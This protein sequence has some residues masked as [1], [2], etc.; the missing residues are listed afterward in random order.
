MPNPRA[1]LR[2]TVLGVGFLLALVVAAWEFIGLRSIDSDDPIQAL[3]SP[4][5]PWGGLAARRAARLLETRW[6][7]DADAAEKGLLWQLGRYPLDPW[8]WLLFTR[9]AS[10]R[11]AGEQELIE[12]LATAISVQ[13]NHREVR[14]QAANLA[15]STGQQNLVLLQLRLLLEVSPN[16]TDQA[17]FIGSRWVEDPAVLLEEILPPGEAY[18]QQ[19]MRRARRIG[20]MALAKAAWS[21]LTQARSGDAGIGPDHPAFSDYIYVALR[22]DRAAAMAA[23][24]SIDAD[25]RPGDLPAGDFSNPLD[26]LPSFGWSLRMPQ[27]TVVE[28]VEIEAPWSGVARPET[29][30]NE[31]TKERKN[32]RTSGAHALRIGFSGEHNV[33][34]N[35]PSVRFPAAAPGFYR[36]RGWWRAEGLTTRALPYLWLDTRS[37]DNRTR[38]RV[39]VPASEFGW[40]VFE[41]DYK[42]HKPGQMV[43]FR[44]HRN[45]TDAFDRY[46]E[47]EITL[48][49][50]S[51]ERLLPS[52]ARPSAP[53]A[54]RRAHDRAVS[55]ADH[56]AGLNDSNESTPY[57]DMPAP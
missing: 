41:I 23:W 53:S 50:L 2:F 4:P 46:I 52:T 13:P 15:Q 26:V 44:L 55:T 38:E 37:G 35:A 36:L 20:S 25:Y 27:G 3:E 39:D 51:A 10:T 1:T 21:R 16:S 54:R 56:E 8:R 40:T 12:L 28:R 49:G 42:V 47:G 48:A 19:T 11:G 6:R 9:I 45:S 43:V 30:P 17:L 18:L 31:R 14:W 24:Q 5:V 22:H 34:L 7:L 57:R 29:E 32:E 33:R